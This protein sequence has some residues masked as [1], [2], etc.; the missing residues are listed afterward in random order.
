MPSASPLLFPELFEDKPDA[1]R[2]FLQ[3]ALQLRDLQELYANARRSEGKPLAQS[4]LDLLEVDLNVS[5][6]DLSR[7]PKEGRVVLTANHPFGILDGM[8]LD[9]LISRVR[10]DVKILTSSLISSLPELRERCLPVDIFGNSKQNVSSLRRV[11]ELLRA[12]HGAAFFPA[13]EVAHWQT[14]RRCI[15]D[16]EW[17]NAAIRCALFTDAPIVPIYFSGANS[18]S[19]Q[20]AGLLHPRLRTARLPGELMNKKGQRVEV[21]IG[22]PLCAAEL[23]RLRSVEEATGYV[24]A[25]TYTLGH[26][27]IAASPAPKVFSLPLMR[28]VEPIAQA[29]ANEHMLQGEVERLQADRGVVVETPEYLALAAPASRMPALLH[30]IGRLREITFRAAGE[31]SGKALDLDDFDR[32]YLQLILWHK[33]RNCVAGGYRLAWTSDVLPSRGVAGLYTS[34][35]F[36]FHPSFFRHL[37]AAVELGRSFV[38]PE[39]QKDYAPLVVLWQA[40]ARL[41]ARRPEAPVLF[42][43]VSISANYSEAA[44]ELIVQFVSEH[45]FRKDLAP[46]VTPRHAFRSRLTSSSDLRV[47]GNCLLDVESLNGPLCDIDQAG[48]V[49]VLLRQYL[50][51]GGRVAGFNLDRRFS[52]ALDGLLIVDLRETSTK[53]LGR[54]MGSELLEAYRKNVS[55]STRS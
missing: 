2:N 51:L 21:R 18:L 14:R 3:A 44:R 26:R 38:R 39:F 27:S 11:I 9:S 28:R 47:L 20:L 54:Y 22:T 13:G 36:R 19:F 29:A 43:P 17:S 33:R 46:L 48:G 15:T 30:E 7:I 25:R 52:N 41:A 55:P 32:H 1:V 42:G 37:G 31:G 8:L 23:K 12:E 24:R 4:I 5:S 45:S 53:M 50:K 16:P 6:Q 49:P 10:P 35:L 34:T 40:I